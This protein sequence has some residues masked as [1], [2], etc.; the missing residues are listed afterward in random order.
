M[1]DPPGEENRG[2][3]LC[4]VGGIHGECD[5]MKETAGVVQCHD[6]HH[7]SAH[8]VNGRDAGFLDKEFGRAGHV[9]KLSNLGTYACVR[10]VRPNLHVNPSLLRQEKPAHRSFSVGGGWGEVTLHIETLLEPL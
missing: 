1:S 8:E 5:D 10:K 6:D 9:A 3:R 2:R 7:H 4:R